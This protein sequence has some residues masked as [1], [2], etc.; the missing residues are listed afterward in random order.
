MKSIS[1]RAWILYALIFAFLAGMCILF[2]SFYTN[3]DR[4]AMRKENRHLYSGNALTAAGAITDER[5]TV[6][7][8]TVDG[9]RI[10]HDDKTVRT[11]TLHVVGDPEGYIATGVQ[12]AYK[13][14]LT[15]YNFADGI[16]DIK[17]YGKGNSITLS[18]NAELC[19]AAYEALGKNKGTVGVMN[20]KT[21]QLVCVVS[22]PAFDIQNK[23]TENINNDKTGAYEGVYLNRF[24]SGLYTPGSTF[25]TITAASA[26]ENI[27]DIDSQ[28]F[29][30]KGSCTIDGG[31]VICLGTHGTVDFERALNVSCNCA[32]SQIAV[33]LGNEKLQ[34]TADSL[35]FNQSYQLGNIR[36]AK[37]RFDLSEANNLDLGWAGVGQYTTLVNPCHMLMITGAVANDGQSVSPYLVSKITTQK[38]RTTFE[39][40]PTAGAQMFSQGTAEKLQEMLR[41]NVKNY[42]GDGKF[43][44][45]QM[46]GK[47]GTAEVSSEAGG[48]K[49]HAW[50]IGFSSREDLP[51][52]IVAVVENGGG[53]SSV[54][55]PVANKTMQKVADLYG[56]KK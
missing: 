6:L 25:K 20:Y 8:D 11:A 43:R 33:Q 49:P 12:T 10:Y 26:I 51:Y 1:R 9:K 16:Y 54:A 35:G 7:A 37:S 39:A 55:I 34:A 22:K 19:A 32:F 24:F 44:G 48:A 42:Y 50:F 45:L 29:K 28:T 14:T 2:T 23:P 17:K 41:S 3:A 38:G 5:G 56:T 21:G 46:C 40:E 30:C 13:D 4:W 52:A 15:G 53:G 18:V 47:T 36:L 27:P 31:T